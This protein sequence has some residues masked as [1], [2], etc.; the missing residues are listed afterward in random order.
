MI[1]GRKVNFSRNLKLSKTASINSGELKSFQDLEFTKSKTSFFKGS[2][3]AHYCS[4]LKLYTFNFNLAITC[5]VVLL[6][7]SNC[8]LIK[9]K[10]I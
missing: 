1:K 10:Y 2:A 5:S 3:G 9:T 6:P 7:S 4:V 8:L